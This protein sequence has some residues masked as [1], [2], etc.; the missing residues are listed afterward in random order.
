MALELAPNKEVIDFINHGGYL[1][2]KIARFY[3]KQLLNAINFIHVSG[4]THRDIKLQNILFN[5]NFDIKVSDFGF[6]TSSGGRKK[7]GLCE[8][9]LGTA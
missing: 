8:T 6:A 7:K 2:E 3:F 9:I 1:P 4:L 5:E